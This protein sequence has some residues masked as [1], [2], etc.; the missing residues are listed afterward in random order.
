MF[1]TLNCPFTQLGSSVL[2]SGSE[3]QGLIS[4]LNV[5]LKTAIV[6]AGIYALLNLLIA[7]YGFMNAGGDTKAVAKAWDRIWQSILGLTVVAGS[8]VLAAIFGQ[9]I[10]GNP[11]ILLNPTIFS[12]I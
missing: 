11:A 10:F 1:G 7:G 8:F 4:L 6:I 9:L 12:P 5:F 3:G 2:C